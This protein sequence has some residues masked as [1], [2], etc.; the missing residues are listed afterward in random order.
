MPS[1]LSFDSA[2]SVS[3]TVR[4]DVIT[5]FV[6]NILEGPQVNLVFLHLTDSRRVLAW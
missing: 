4:S 5:P 3:W 6:S 2:A 1:M